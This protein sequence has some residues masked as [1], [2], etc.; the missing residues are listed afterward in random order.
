MPRRPDRPQARL[1]ARS[2]RFSAAANLLAALS[3]LAPQLQAQAPAPQQTQP[4]APAPQQDQAQ[5]SQ[6][7]HGTVLFERHLPP[8]QDTPANQPDPPTPTQPA[9]L[10]YKQP[11]RRAGLQKRGKAAATTATPEAAQPAAAS[12]GSGSQ[13]SR[14]EHPATEGSTAEGEAAEAAAAQ[15]PLATGRTLL[16]HPS[17]TDQKAAEA[18]SNADRDAVQIISTDLDL[19]L[20]NSTGATE[21]R[22]RLRIR[23]AGAA[24]LPRV[25]LSISSSLHW[26]SAR[27]NTG[28]T[29][30]AVPFEQHLLLT[31]LDHTGGASEIAVTLPAP[32]APG[33][34]A[35]LDLFYE[36]TLAASAERLRRLGAPLDQAART[37]WDSVSPVFTGLRGAGN[38]LWYPVA[39]S[40]TFLGDGVAFLEHIDRLRRQDAAAPMGLHLALEFTGNRPDAAYFLGQRQPLVDAA[41]PTAA[42]AAPAISTSAAPAT[43]QPDNTDADTETE[44]RSGLAV[45]TWPAVA[46]DRHLPS[47]FIA[48][49]APVRGSD[50]APVQ[51][52]GVDPA[53]TDFNAA[54]AANFAQAAAEVQPLLASW[55]GARPS[56]MLT[57]L[58]LPIANA[59]PFADGRLLVAPLAIPPERP[60]AKTSDAD[61]SADAASSEP[62]PR[63]AG[64]RPG[65]LIVPLTAAWLPAGIPQPWLRDGLAEFLRVLWVERTDGRE[66]AL[67]NLAADADL[68]AQREAFAGAGDESVAVGTAAPPVSAAPIAAAAAPAV[69]AAA[70]PLQM[71]TAAPCARTKAAYVFGMLRSIAGQNA[72]QQALAAWRVGA[73]KDPRQGTAARLRTLLEQTSGKQLQWFFAD[74]VETDRGLP[75]LTI[76]AVAPRRLERSSGS[77]VTPHRSPVAGPIGPEPVPQP[78]DPLSSSPAPL[79][80][81]NGIAPAEGSWLVAVEVQ[82]NG[83]VAAEVPVTVRAGNLV[84]V[85]PLR[86]PAH[87][88]A[89]VRVPFEAEPQEVL[90]NDG[91]VP[92]MR[93]STHRRS[94]QPAAAAEK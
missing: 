43:Q 36:G 94:I 85:L 27:Q 74:W 37:D 93:T 44:V 90:V 75:D 62:P 82:N 61:T 64:V 7:A 72:L 49:A 33:A 25:A 70:Q 2:A 50:D 41:A 59:A 22:A 4:Q 39:A 12:T 53:D 10:P 23:N 40:P 19:H 84:N 15:S 66:H 42:A 3:L 35:S 83:G 76:V 71:C 88:K 31:D 89:T 73:E 65:A 48:N 57:V 56:G 18:I 6:P 51:V 91:T 69:N 87:G 9:P 16:L 21:A 26:Q 34:E 38:V 29:S 32:L 63:P 5:P 80:P 68:L 92:E 77:V 86:V 20:N 17:D 1:R 13:P 45:A 79:A 67:A 55:L 30:V 54:V 58:E 81:V 78:G 46:L 47:L 14:T 60:A 52:A 8:V 11:A 28:G 24:A